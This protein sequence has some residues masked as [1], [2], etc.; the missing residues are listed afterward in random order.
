VEPNRE[1]PESEREARDKKPRFRIIKL[2]ER[3]A[4]KG[5]QGG[6]GQPTDCARCYGT[7][8]TGRF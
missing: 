2:E 7:N 3:I 8:Q 5:H 1:I 6:H 4:P